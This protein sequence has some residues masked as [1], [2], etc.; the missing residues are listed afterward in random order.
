MSTLRTL[1]W[2]AGGSP[3]EGRVI[4]NG[5]EQAAPG[6]LAQTSFALCPRGRRFSHPSTRQKALV[7]LL[8]CR[9]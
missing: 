1:G 3:Q 7:M 5:T 8:R 2:E 9:S 6:E 4:Y